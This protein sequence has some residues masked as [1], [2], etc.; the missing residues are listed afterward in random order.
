[1]TQSKLD[2]VNITPA[3]LEREWQITIQTPVGGLDNLLNALACAIS[4]K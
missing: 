3:H 2:N 1:M 4:L